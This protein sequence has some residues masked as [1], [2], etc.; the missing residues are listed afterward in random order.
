MDSDRMGSI[1]TA[2]P[3]VQSLLNK[4]STMKQQLE[5]FD[6]STISQ[7]I[8]TNIHSGQNVI[9]SS[10]K[11]FL[12]YL[13]LRAISLCLTV[14]TVSG[15]ILLK[16]S[17]SKVNANEPAFSS[18]KGSTSPFIFGGAVINLSASK[19]LMS[20]SGLNSTKGR[21]SGILLE[22]CKCYGQKVEK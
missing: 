6:L 20:I 19:S 3:E 13:F 1:L 18:L 10:G 9:C 22:F 14:I 2:A 17:L 12:K 16:D 5:V 21:I 7:K 8:L 11:R 4:S 15:S